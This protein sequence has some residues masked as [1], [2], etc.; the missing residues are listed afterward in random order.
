MLQEQ[1]DATKVQIKARLRARE[2]SQRFEKV[3]GIAPLT[4]SALV[5]SIGEA[6]DFDIGL[7]F[8]VRLDEAP[9]GTAAA[10]NQCCWA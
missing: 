2:V 7:Q 5:A 10:A 1:V 9:D 6:K 4:A 8:A 3:Q